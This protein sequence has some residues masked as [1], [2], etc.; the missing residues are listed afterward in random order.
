MRN[1]LF[2]SYQL[3]DIMQSQKQLHGAGAKGRGA[4]AKYQKREIVYCE[5]AG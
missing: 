5:R 3:T 4:N 2:T 1:S